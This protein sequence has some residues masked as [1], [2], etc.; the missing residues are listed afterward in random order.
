MVLW[1]WLLL[2]VWQ[3]LKS[4]KMKQCF[5]RMIKTVIFQ[6]TAVI[7]RKFTSCK[8]LQASYKLGQSCKIVT[9]ISILAR[10]WMQWHSCKLLARN[11]ALSQ[12]FCQKWICLLWRSS[13]LLGTTNKDSELSI[14]EKRFKFRGSEFLVLSQ[15]CR[16]NTV[17]DY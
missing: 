7:D 15:L 1:R 12:E 3:I 2:F 11:C 10:S 14:H 4:V 8:I 17:L 13:D 16:S 5:R 9:K 6:K